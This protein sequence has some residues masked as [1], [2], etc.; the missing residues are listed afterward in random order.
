[1]D[2]NRLNEKNELVFEEA[3]YDLDGLIRLVDSEEAAMVFMYYDED[4]DRYYRNRYDILECE[5]GITSILAR[6]DRYLEQDEANGLFIAYAASHDGKLWLL[7][8]RVA[9]EGDLNL[10]ELELGV[11]LVYGVLIRKEEETFVFSEVLYHDGGETSSS[12]A[13]TVEDAGVLTPA[14]RRLIGQFAD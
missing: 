9:E 2:E 11:N 8:G 14:L 10:G 7:D 3:D 1:M 6:T 13:T 5:R 12:W 4:D